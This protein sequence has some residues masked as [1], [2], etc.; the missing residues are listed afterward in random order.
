M[1]KNHHL[2]QAIGDSALGSFVTK[3]GY[4][5]EWLGKTILMIAKFE[6]SSKICHVCGYYIFEL[7]PK[8]IEWK[9]PDCKTKHEEI[10]IC[11]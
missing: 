11:N 3:L 4:K 7:T 10:L 2:T 5:S 8:D 6:P 1:I 9:F